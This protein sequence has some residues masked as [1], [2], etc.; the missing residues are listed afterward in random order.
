MILQWLLAT[1]KYSRC[2]STSFPVIE[3]V[4]MDTVNNGC[5]ILWC[6]PRMAICFCWY[7]FLGDKAFHARKDPFRIK[8]TPLQAIFLKMAVREVYSF[9]FSKHSQYI[10][11]IIFRDMIATIISCVTEVE[12]CFCGKTVKDSGHAH[13]T[14]GD[15][16]FFFPYFKVKVTDVRIKFLL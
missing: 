6:A 5:V 13:V 9:Y 3:I 2:A 12:F 8:A 7:L 11:N 10:H 16:W 15:I 4:V 14:N 1:T